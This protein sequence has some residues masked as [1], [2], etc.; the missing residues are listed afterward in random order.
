MLPT[1]RM[2]GVLFNPSLWAVCV[3]LEA[4]GKGRERATY[5]L[6]M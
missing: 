2:D 1:G 3:W 5:I 6:V 4:E